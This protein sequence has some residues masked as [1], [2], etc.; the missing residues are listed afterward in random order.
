MVVKIINDRL[1]QIWILT[2]RFAYNPELAQNNMRGEN[3][4]WILD[5]DDVELT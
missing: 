5:G 1:K 2:H 3:L 4:S